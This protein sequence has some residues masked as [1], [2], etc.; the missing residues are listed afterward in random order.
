MHAGYV[1][2]YV[3]NLVSR[4][5]I[6]PQLALHWQKR[7]LTLHSLFIQARGRLS[8]TAQQLRSPSSHCVLKWLKPAKNKLLLSFH[9]VFRANYFRFRSLHALP[10]PFIL[11]ICQTVANITDD[12]SISRIFQFNFWAGF[13][14]LAQL[15]CLC[16]R[17][18]FRLSITMTTCNACQ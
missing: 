6:M 14:H 7:F 17:Q 2:K 8:P 11:K 10:Q 16:S 12:K 13:F 1:S 18:S 9:E 4:Q 5:N 15:C 3:R